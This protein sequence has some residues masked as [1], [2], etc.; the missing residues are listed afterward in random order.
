MA[1]QETRAE[2]LERLKS[3]AIRKVKAALKDRGITVPE[4]DGPAKDDAP[5]RNV[6]EWQ[7]LASAF[8]A[9]ENSAHAGNVSSYPSADAMDSAPDAGKTTGKKGV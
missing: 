2:S 4:I 8:D 5:L 7:A 9:A 6:Q 3:A 1:K